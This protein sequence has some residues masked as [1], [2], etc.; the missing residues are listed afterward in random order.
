M[1]LTLAEYLNRFSWSQARLCRESGVSEGVV[2]RAL[3]GE[4]ISRDSAD[5]IIEALDRKFREKG[6]KGHIVMG[7][8]TGLKIA[9][10]Q[11]TQEPADTE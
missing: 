6:A 7:S 8:I 9:D 10:L 11:R 1:Q 4:T 2:R 3:R 5:K